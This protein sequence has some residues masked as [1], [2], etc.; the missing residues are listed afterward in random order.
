[1]MTGALVNTAA[2][3][4]GGLFGQLFGRALKECHQQTLTMACGVST[5][6]IGTS[7]ALKHMLQK[8]RKRKKKSK[9]IIM[10]KA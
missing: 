1:M 8:T 2:I 9:L 7:G 10:Q 6:F 3:A 5:M 4:A